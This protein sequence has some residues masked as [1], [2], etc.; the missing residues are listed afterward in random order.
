MTKLIELTNR[1]KEI[2][3]FVREF[4]S[5]NTNTIANLYWKDCKQKQILVERILKLLVDNKK[6]RIDR[7]SMLDSYYYY[8]GTKPTN[9]KHSCLIAEAYTQLNLSYTIL[10]YKRD[11]EL[12]YLNQ[13]ILADLV[14]IIKKDNKPLPLIIEVDISRPYNHKYDTYINSNYWNFKFGI[15][16]T[17]I[18]ISKW[19]PKS[20]VLIEY[21]N[22]EMFKKTG[23]LI[24]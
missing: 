21:I 13:S 19:K 10:N 18:S 4:K 7:E 8:V 23:L 2:I 12:K 20:N 17:I 3:S 11:L 6:L 1:D 15:I 16:P 22:V 14:A 5:V 24:R 9:F